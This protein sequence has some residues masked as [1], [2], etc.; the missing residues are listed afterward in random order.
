MAT[1]GLSSLKLTQQ[2]TKHSSVRKA[3]TVNML[4]IYSHKQ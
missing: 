3:T 4:Y 1:V 2:H